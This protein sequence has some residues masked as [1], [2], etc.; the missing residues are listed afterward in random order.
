MSDGGVAIQTERKL[1]DQ[2]NLAGVPFV[3]PLSLVTLTAPGRVLF[4]ELAQHGL[5]VRGYG[6]H[7][8][9]PFTLLYG[10]A[11]LGCPPP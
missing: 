5:S 7:G 11:L 8:L 6:T 2:V 4:F 3:V 9:S 1:S 10:G